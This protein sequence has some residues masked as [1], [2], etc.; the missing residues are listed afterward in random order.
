MKKSTQI[1]WWILRIVLGL[2]MLLGAVTHVTNVKEGAMVD[3]AF[4]TA[5]VNTGY[6]WQIIGITELLA[7]LA[8]L[9]GRFVP[10][11]LVLLAPITLNIL[12][13][14]L[15]RP[16]PDGISIALAI[17]LPH[18]GLA[19]LYREHFSS[20]FKLNSSLVDASEPQA[21]NSRA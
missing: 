17:I 14:H 21:I 8:I 13:F 19:W 18:L 5:M 3:S 10:L 4:I 15:S 6:L 7:G 1:I 16:S 12:L 11:A 20:L 2:L 9:A